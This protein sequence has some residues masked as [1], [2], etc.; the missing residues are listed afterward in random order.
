MADRNLLEILTAALAKPEAS[1]QVQTESRKERKDE[2]QQLAADAEWYM[3]PDAQHE[4]VKRF[5][6][7]NVSLTAGRY[8][9]AEALDNERKKRLEY[10]YKFPR[11]VERSK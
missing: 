3:S 4:F 9:T 7:G 6:R 5:S 10:R 11:P 1:K 8:L 2:E